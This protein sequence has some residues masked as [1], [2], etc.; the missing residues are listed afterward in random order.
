MMLIYQHGQIRLQNLFLSRIMHLKTVIQL[1]GSIQFL[2]S[3]KEV[4]KLIPQ[5]IFINH[6][7]IQLKTISNFLIYRE[8]FIQKNKDGSELHQLSCLN[9]RDILFDKFTNRKLISKLKFLIRRLNKCRCRQIQTSMKE[10]RNIVTQKSTIV[11]SFKGQ[12]K[13]EN[14]TQ[15]N[16]NKE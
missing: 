8:K 6:M 15:N 12:K 14:N 4:H 1:L 2:D 10:F 9:S 13:K 16:S 5:I 3:T 11:K 7:F